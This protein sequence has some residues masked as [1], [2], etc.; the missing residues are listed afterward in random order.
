MF[1][2]HKHECKTIKLLGKNNRAGNFSDIGLDDE[3]LRYDTK[4]IFTK[5]K[6][7]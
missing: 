1:H 7:R 2:K 3:L 6:M 4:S 5:E